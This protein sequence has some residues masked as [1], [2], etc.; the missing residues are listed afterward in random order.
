MLPWQRVNETVAMAM[1]NGDNF[2]AYLW[3]VSN[4]MVFPTIEALDGHS[5]QPVCVG[6]GHD[7]A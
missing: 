4:M 3:A 1:V 5:P 2:P 6:G 7:S